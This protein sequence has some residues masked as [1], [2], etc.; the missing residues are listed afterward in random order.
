MRYGIHFDHEGYEGRRHILS[1]D[2]M[3]FYAVCGVRLDALRNASH[4]TCKNC[5]RILLAE[6]KKYG[7]KQWLLK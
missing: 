2:H 5:I 6:A 7:E 4:A 3:G 1:V